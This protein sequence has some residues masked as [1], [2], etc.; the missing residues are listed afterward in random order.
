MR[1]KCVELYSDLEV[2]PSFLWCVFKLLRGNFMSLTKIVYLMLS[3][4][5]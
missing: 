2:A 4:V 3:V 1:Q 5:M